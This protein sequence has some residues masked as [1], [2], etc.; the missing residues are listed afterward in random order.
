MALNWDFSKLTTIKYET[1]EYNPNG[2][3]D[4]ISI[5]TD[6]ADIRFVLADKSSV[7]C[8]G[9]KNAKHSV[10]VKDGTLRIEL[11]NKLSE[12]NV[13]Y[14]SG[15]AGDM[16]WPLPYSDVYVSSRFKFRWG[17]QHNGIDTCRWSGTQ[18]AD[19][20]SVKKGT[21]E[22]ANWGWGGG[23]GNY[24]VVNAGKYFDS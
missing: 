1:N 11:E 18:G 8:Y 17:K 14:G 5:D 3:F 2:Q 12:K 7:S 13:Y 22:V 23:Y 4:S 24:V 19:V 10:S 9:E 15:N 16:V 20:V 6:T 21:I